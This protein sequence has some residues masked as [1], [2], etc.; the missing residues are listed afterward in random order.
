MAR[1]PEATHVWSG[2][3]NSPLFWPTPV[4]AS[5]RCRAISGPAAF[6][7]AGSHQRARFQD[8]TAGAQLGHLGQSRHLVTAHRCGGDPQLAHLQTPM[9]L[10][11]GF[12][13]RRS[14][15]LYEE[16]GGVGIEG[17]LVL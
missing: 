3:L 11:D 14:A 4:G 2:P 9:P 12:F 17:E 10:V 13:I 1:L 7:A 5:V 8:E 16:V 6:C 15:G